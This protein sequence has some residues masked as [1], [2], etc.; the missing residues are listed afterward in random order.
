MISLYKLPYELRNYVIFIKK[1]INIKD[2]YYYIL[3]RRDINSYF[4]NNPDHILIKFF[5]NC[6]N[7]EIDLILKKNKIEKNVYFFENFNLFISNFKERY[8]VNIFDP[9]YNSYSNP[10]LNCCDRHISTTTQLFHHLDDCKYYKNI[11]FQKN[12]SNQ[13]KFFFIIDNDFLKKKNLK[14]ILVSDTMQ[15]LKKL[16]RKK[17][18][19]LQIIPIYDDNINIHDIFVSDNIGVCFDYL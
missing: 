12:K 13:L 15:F 3:E 5:V 6:R 10:R 11:L 4:K 8:K 16:K 18:Q 9:V 17:Y 7:L 1:K 14:K 2:N 19:I